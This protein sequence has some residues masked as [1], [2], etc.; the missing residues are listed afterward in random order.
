MDHFLHWI[1][2]N[3]FKLKWITRQRQTCSC[4]SAVHHRVASSFALQMFAK[5]MSSHDSQVPFKMPF[6]HCDVET[7]KCKSAFWR[8]TALYR[9][10][11]QC[12]QFAFEC[13]VILDFGMD[14]RLM[15]IIKTE[16]GIQLNGQR[17]KNLILRAI[18]W[19][20]IGPVA[21][22]TFPICHL[23]ARREPTMFWST[24]AIFPI[25]WGHAH[26][27]ARFPEPFQIKIQDLLVTVHCPSPNSASNVATA[28]VSQNGENTWHLTHYESRNAH[29]RSRGGLATWPWR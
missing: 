27:L 3:I 12:L 13:T 1:I 16:N 26:R 15:T 25:T 20:S 23:G 19:L 6:K 17:W 18:A 24:R 5:W 10:S 9:S 7:R 29:G 28:S 4:S 14:L 21:P 11:T 22:R 8:E 2:M